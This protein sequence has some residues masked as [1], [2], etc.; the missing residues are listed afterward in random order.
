MITDNKVFIKNIFLHEGILG[1]LSIDIYFYPDEKEYYK[2]LKNNDQVMC[3][4]KMNKKELR[5]YNI[6]QQNNIFATL[7]SFL[8]V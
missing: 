4:Y 5:K 1:C 8:H 6:Q 7:C 3:I 2:F